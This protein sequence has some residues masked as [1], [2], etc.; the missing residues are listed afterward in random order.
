MIHPASVYV[1]AE[2]IN[3]WWRKKWMFYSEIPRPWSTWKNLQITVTYY[4]IEL[5]ILKLL[6]IY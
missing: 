4:S 5:L 6:L 1:P 3:V 2:G